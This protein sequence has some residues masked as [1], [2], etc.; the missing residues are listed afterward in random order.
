MTD[1]AKFLKKST[2]DLDRFAVALDKMTATSSDS[3]QEDT[4]F[5]KPE[6]DKSGNA[7]AVIRFLPVSPADGDDSLPWVRIFDHGFKG[8]SG[9]WYIEKSLTTLNQKDP[10]SEYNSQLWNSTTDDASPARKQAREQKRRLS[11]YSNIMV[12]SDPK[13]PENEG[14]VFLFKFGKKIFD[15][16]TAQMKPEF[17]GDPSVNVFDLMKGA[18]FRLRMRQ[19]AG[20]PNYDESRFDAPSA[21]ND[22]MKTLENIW[23]SEYSLKELVDPKNF[24]SYEELKRRLEEVLELN[25]SPGVGGA[26]AKAVAPTNTVKAKETE[27]TPP[28]QGDEDEDDELKQFQAL[29]K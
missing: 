15:K 11:Y 26:P 17:D 4:R 3:K 8:P 28:W 13:R 18:N 2:T 9:K 5:W 14:K 25:V 7:S 10:V 12:I 20:F 29:A 22:D 1:F 23:R 16:I 6:R 27:D 19:V 21:L 24:K